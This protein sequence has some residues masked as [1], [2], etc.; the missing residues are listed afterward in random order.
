MHLIIFLL[1]YAYNGGKHYTIDIVLVVVKFVPVSSIYVLVCWEGST[2][3]K[4]LAKSIFRSNVIRAPQGN[5]VDHGIFCRDSSLCFVI[6]F[7]H[8]KLTGKF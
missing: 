2:D 1:A 8:E 5:I 4:I 7:F 6:W 3:V